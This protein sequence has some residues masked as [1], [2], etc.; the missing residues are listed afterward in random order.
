MESSWDFD[1]NAEYTIA[2]S[3]IDRLTGL[4]LTLIERFNLRKIVE[5]S[6]FR[7]KNVISRINIFGPAEDATILFLQTYYDL[8]CDADLAKFEEMEDERAH[9]RKEK[10]YDAMG[11]Y[12]RKKQDE[13]H[14]P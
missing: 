11:M 5:E 9:M 3:L 4:D 6:I 7:R 14:C 12:W 10:G 1:V 2:L 8:P 13:A